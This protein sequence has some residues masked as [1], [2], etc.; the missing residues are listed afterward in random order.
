MRDEASSSGSLKWWR[1]LLPKRGRNERRIP[2]GAF[3]V[4]WI[5]YLHWW[6]TPPGGTIAGRRGGSEGSSASVSTGNGWPQ[7]ATAP[8]RKGISS[9]GIITPLSLHCWWI[10][11]FLIVVAEGVLL[12]F[13]GRD[14]ASSVRSH[15]CRQDGKE[16]SQLLVCQKSLEDRW[17]HYC[18]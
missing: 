12:T 3:N 5:D 8:R 10:G 4:G 16:A 15:V 14:K 9:L 1:L 7:G 18:I 17:T 6:K 13:D 11:T 2:G